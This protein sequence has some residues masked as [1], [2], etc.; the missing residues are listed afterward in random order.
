MDL[1]RRT[2]PAVGLFF[3]APLVAEFLLGNLPITLLPALVLLAPLYGGGALLIREVT[4]RAGR[5]VPTM[6]VLGV[7]LRAAGGGHR[8]PVAVQPA[9]RRA[10]P[11]QRRLRPV[12]GD[13]GAVDAVRADP[14]R[15]G[16]H[17][18]ADRRWPSCAPAERTGPW[19]GRPG[20]VVD[21]GAARRR[22]RRERRV[23]DGNDPFRASPAQFVG[24]VVLAALA[25]ASGC[26]SP[27]ARTCPAPCPRR[28]RS[29]SSGWW[30]AWL[31]E[32]APLS[33]AGVAV[34]VALWVGLAALAA[35]WSVRAAWTPRHT[36]AAAAA[37]LVTYAWHAFPETPVVPASPV[38]RSGRQ[39][40]LRARRGTADRDGLA[41]D[42]RSEHHRHQ[43][44]HQQLS[45]PR[46]KEPN[47]EDRGHPGHQGPYRPLHPPL[48]NG[49]RCRQR[50]RPHTGGSAAGARRARHDRGHRLR[51][52]HRAGPRP[53]RRGHPR[54]G[55][56]R[57]DDPAGAHLHL[58]PCRWPRPWPP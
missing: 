14:A 50:A 28:G 25:D 20:L 51:A 13:R 58:R 36:L 5:G 7:A 40:R 11:A 4:R 38:R 24:V 17:D 3:L 8:H 23:P 18:R 43:Q 52:R 12:A 22:D 44:R 15:G 47:R 21:G 46:A 9:L 41:P 19:L 30:R 42:G 27:A 48:E 39:R 54:A 33:Y 35:R 32:L 45:R 34:L 55:G 1:L 31:S 37:A 6:L 56:H 29:G 26:G 53:P 10:R 49:R 16:Q 57:G 2:A